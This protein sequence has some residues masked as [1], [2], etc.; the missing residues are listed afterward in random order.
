MPQF[1]ILLVDDSKSI[2]K[3]LSRVFKSEGY[4]IYT[5]ESANNAFL[6]LKKEKIDL[7]ITDENMPGITGNDLLKMA[8]EHF[9]ETIRIMITGMIDISVARNA[10]NSGKIYKLFNKPWDDFELLLAVRYA[11][12]Q[13]RLKEENEQ[14]KSTIDSQAELLKKLENEY[15]GITSK[16]MSP[17]GALIIEE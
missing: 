5:A 3:A 1:S 14:L 8:Q 7:L 4:K 16:N 10:I 11:L 12:N 15:P 2:L 9:P 17:D 13:K 6:I